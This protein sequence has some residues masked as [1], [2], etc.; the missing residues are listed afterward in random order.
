[1]QSGAVW[2]E[3]SPAHISCDPLWGAESIRFS[4]NLTIA[5]VRLAVFCTHSNLTF[6]LKST[7]LQ[8][9]HNVA[10]V[11]IQLCMDIMG[12]ANTERFK[13]F[14]FDTFNL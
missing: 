8:H 14:R 3:M 5:V 10:V 12:F 9:A 7:K 2:F 4:G 13:F 6:A 1:M 11:S